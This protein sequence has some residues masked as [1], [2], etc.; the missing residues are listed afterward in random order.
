MDGGVDGWVG[1]WKVGGWME[2]RITLQTLYAQNPKLV[3]A[4]IG[5]HFHYIQ[6][7]ATQIHLSHI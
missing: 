7:Y 6:V 1:R 5:L 3:L 2:E 4:H